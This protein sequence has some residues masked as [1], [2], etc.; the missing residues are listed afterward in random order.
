MPKRK[1]ENELAKSI[2]DDIIEETESEDWNKPKKLS[3]QKG[4]KIRAAKLTP[5]ERSAIAKKAAQ[6]R[7][8]KSES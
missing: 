4:G 7:W 1:D 3:A 5:A 2:I 6:S 8:K